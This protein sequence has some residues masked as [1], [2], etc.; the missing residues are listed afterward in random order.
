MGQAVGRGGDEGVEGEAGV[1][2]DRG[3]V[4]RPALPVA[5]RWR[6][7]PAGGAVGGAVARRRPGRRPD[8]R[9]LGRRRTVAST[10]WRRTS[11][12]SPA[13]A[14]RVSSIRGRN[15]LSTRSRTTALGTP[16]TSDAAVEGDRLGS[17]TA[18]SATWCPRPVHATTLCSASTA[19]WFRPPAP[20]RTWA[21]ARP[22]RGPQVWNTRDARGRSNGT[23]CRAARLVARPD[24]A[25]S[26][27]GATVPDRRLVRPADLA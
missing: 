10:T 3:R 21:T 5:A 6:A 11:T 17:P 2:R 20:P 25:P 24:A 19:R 27:G 23:P 9:A 13:M 22:Q 14:A 1:E 18:T 12:G 7:G 16:R 8:R 26:L 15:R 4:S